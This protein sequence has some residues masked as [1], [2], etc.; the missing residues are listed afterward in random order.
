MKRLEYEKTLTQILKSTLEIN[1]L[2]IIYSYSLVIWV[3]FCPV[4]LSMYNLLPV[5]S[6]CGA[7]TSC[8]LVDLKVPCNFIHMSG[9]LEIFFRRGLHSTKAN[10][11]NHNFSLSSSILF[12][13]NYIRKRGTGA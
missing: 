13:F 3:L 2:L 4:P 7:K 11:G 6:S 10:H 5:K 8:Q 1:Q 9:F 12:L